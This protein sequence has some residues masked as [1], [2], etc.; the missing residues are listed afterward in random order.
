MRGILTATQDQFFSAEDESVS[1]VQTNNTK[2]K[3]F[4]YSA[5][6][7]PYYLFVQ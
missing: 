6:T 3:R 2:V 7:L 5:K 1:A 4:R